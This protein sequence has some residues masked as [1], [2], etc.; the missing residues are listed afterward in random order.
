MIRV[1]LSNLGVIS[2]LRGD[3]EAAENYYDQALV[4]IRKTAP[5]SLDMATVLTNLGGL[6]KSR[7]DLEAAFGYYQEALE[8]KNRLAPESL[9]VAGS[10]HNLGAVLREQLRFEESRSY[11]T[12]AWQIRRKLSDSNL[13][14]AASLRDMGYVARDTGNISLARRYFEKALAIQRKQALEGLQAA[15]TLSALGELSSR[16]GEL[17]EAIRHHEAALSIRRRI[18]PGS[19]DEASSLFFLARIHLALGEETQSLDLMRSALRSLQEQAVRVG[20]SADAKGGFN[21]SAAE[22]YRFAIQLA[23]RRRENAWAFSSLE[24]FRAQ[25]FLA[26]LAEKDLD[27]T[28]DI[29]PELELR[30]ARLAV[31]LDRA[32][33][34]FHRPDTVSRLGAGEDRSARQR[35]LERE[36][37]DVA[38][39]IRRACP[40]LASLQYPQPVDASRARSALDAGTV[41]LSYL[42][43]EKEAVLFILSRDDD[44][45]VQTLPIGESELRQRIGRFRGLTAEARPG[46]ELGELR[47]AELHRLSKELYN[48]L[49][50]PAADRIE[51]ADRVLIV[52][53]GP[54]HYL[55]FAALVREA[56]DEGGHSHD[57]YLAEWKPF[58]SVLSATV[59]AEIEKD[60]R[61]PT[62]PQV[63]SPLLLNAFG[64]PQFP[65]GLNG[66]EPEE[67]SDIRVRSAVRRGILRFEPLPSTRQEVE[68]IASLF[69]P[70]Q[71]AIFLGAEATEERAKAIG[72]SARILHF[73]THARLDDRFPLNSALVLTMPKGFPE[74]RDN[75]L[76]QVWEIF[77]KVRLDADLVVLSA[78]DTGLG[79][80][81]G[82]EGLIGLTRAFQYAGA[83]TVI[84]SLWSVQDQ[85]T[86]E[87]MIRFYK[88]LRSGQTKDEALRQAQMELIHGPI[89]VLNKKGER[90]LLD[91]S[92][93]YFWAG[94]QVYG[95]WQ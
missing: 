2:S 26:Y 69:P 29:P 58:H 60:R 77:E 91:A 24:Q 21:A 32:A 64:D 80:E 13:D 56:P 12:S 30:R 31:E 36:R 20:D 49:V 52:A 85:A 61:G 1:A 54:L 50:G 90:A 38:R 40:R 94:F 5:D 51:R 55:P 33:T 74:D 19:F 15:T 23:V 14:L 59:Y 44:L 10:L 75:G 41:L 34:D 17:R 70:E 25:G 57:Q 63:G 92:A 6:A 66:K 53:D 28:G 48:L 95:D 81:Q 9:A 72:K 83:R 11:Y 73:A 3:L 39:S 62:K 79:E 4:V 76:L 27:L 82:G 7:G 71:V 86:S 18:S 47:L 37:N 46:T 16:S 84:A 43:G 89:E 68:G 45:H 93:P 87:L 42:I 78:C 65:P 22:I 67:I 8:I 88:H 35:R